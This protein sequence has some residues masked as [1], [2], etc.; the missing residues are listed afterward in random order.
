MEIL[1]PKKQPTIASLLQTR[2][3]QFLEFFNL[4][5]VLR[6]E[7]GCNMDQN[8]TLKI[9][10]GL[11]QYNNKMYTDEMD[12]LESIKKNIDTKNKT[13]IDNVDPV[14]QSIRSDNQKMI[15]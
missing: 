11:K 10:L 1:K 8:N 12:L 3:I 7:A 15:Q 2:L 5:H 9:C 6:L 13:L 4:F 14:W